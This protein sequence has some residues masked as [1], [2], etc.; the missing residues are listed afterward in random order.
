MPRISLTWEH[1]PPLQALLYWQVCLVAA[2]LGVLALH[3]PQC[4]LLS[5]AVLLWADSRLHPPPLSASP[6]PH[7]PTGLPWWR[8][9]LTLACF[10]GSWLVALNL[11][12]PL[13]DSPPPALSGTSPKNPPRLYGVVEKVQG[14]TD[15]RLRIILERVTIDDATPLQGKVAWTWEKA[16]VRPLAGEK[17]SLARPLLPVQGFQNA[18]TKDWGFAARS[19]GIFWRVWSKENRGE[20]RREATAE[21]TGNADM[22]PSQWREALRQNFLALLQGS[23][24]RLL[25]NTAH[26]TSLTQAQ[27]ILP[28]LLFGDRSNLS[29]HTVELF[30]RGTLVHSLAL[31]GQHLAVTALLAAILLTLLGRVWAGVFLR[32]PRPK[33]LIAC[34]LPLAALYLWLGNAPYS[35]QRAACMMLLVALFLWREKAMTTMDILCAAVLCLMLL[36]P[37]SLF[38]LGMQLSILCV[39]SI[40]LTVPIL[41]TLP[42]LQQPYRHSCWVRLCASTLRGIAGIMLVS[43]TIQVALLPVSLLVFGTVSPW[44]ILNILWLPVLAFC[45]LPLAALGL[46]L[47]SLHML[48]PVPLWLDCASTIVQ[49]AQWPCAL[50]LQGLQWLYDMNWLVIPTFLRPHWTAIPAF[51]A[52]LVAT[53]LLWGRS[54]V[55]PASLRLALAGALLLLVAPTLRYAERLTPQLTL[56]MLD[57]GQGQAL[58]LVLPQGQRVL[59]D[60]G[61]SFSPRFDVGRAVVSPTLTY[62]Q[63]PRLDR[64]INTHPHADHLKGLLYILENFWVGA[65]N[66]NGQAVEKTMAQTLHRLLQQQGIAD[67]VLVAGDHLLLC[68]KNR[69]VLEVLYPPAGMQPEKENNASLILRLVEETPQQ[70]T[71]K[72]TGSQGGKRG[73]ILFMADLEKDGINALL[74]SGCDLQAEV[75]VVPHHGSKTG[76]SPALYDAVQPRVALVSYGKGNRYGSPSPEVVEALKRRGIPLYGTGDKGQVSLRWSGKK[77]ELQRDLYQ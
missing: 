1:A 42:R 58:A 39:G 75:L 12:P 61:G 7:M 32:I 71:H 33:L 41:R 50:L 19:Q 37:L 43:C 54:H 27:A 63:P 35:L 30:T 17:W 65:W 4:A 69:L 52:L 40:A 5:M 44:F 51:A 28:A 72:S 64:I 22:T 70:T 46:L 77:L 10:A 66:H 49:V 47:V 3:W 6:P 60:G 48:L 56:H 2:L 59:I 9:S 18:G 11:L 24:P 68:D 67:K 76:Y 74:A 8:L 55:P 16:P 13:P 31:S 57:V 53:A 73:L 25:P 15:N 23:A 36:S 14:L 34:A 21:K 20:A 26:T 45:V 29:D 62:N 38:D